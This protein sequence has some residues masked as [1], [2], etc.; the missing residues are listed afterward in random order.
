MRPGRNTAGI[1][2]RLLRLLR[3]FMLLLQGLYFAGVHFPKADNRQR[4]Q[5]K[6]RWSR[7]LLDCLAIRLDASAPRA[8]PE[9]CLL[10]AN[11][12]SW[13]DIFAIQSL[14]PAVFVAKAEIRHW[15]LV[16]RLCAGA[17]TIF[18]ERGRSAA[19]RRVNARLAHCLQQGTAGAIFPE[20]TTTPG[21]DVAPFRGA[22]FQAA[23]DADAVVQPIVIRYHDGQGHHSDA[24]DYVGETGFLQSLW[25]VVSA[26][27]L[28]VE[29]HFLE[30]VPARNQSRQSLAS[31]SR[32]IIQAGLVPAAGPAPGKSRHPPVAAL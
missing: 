27:S 30:P 19:A 26:A 18:I 20:G 5:F 13:V 17:G 31:R 11:H 8:L 28:A 1:L 25:S 14:H 2:L 29:L 6:R 3:V 22:L 12:I 21:R 9:R 23:I 32:A 10:V 7:R 16:G 24:A 4:R 15:P